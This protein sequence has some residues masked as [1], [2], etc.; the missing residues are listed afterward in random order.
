MQPTHECPGIRAHKVRHKDKEGGQEVRGPWS[1]R[2]NG[3]LGEHLPGSNE[4][5][6]LR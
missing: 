4:K 3:A 2:E 5:M 1:D 6:G